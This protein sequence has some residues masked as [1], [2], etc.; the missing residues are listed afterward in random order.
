MNSV[1]L[2]PVPS[3]S[4]LGPGCGPCVWPLRERLALASALLDV[5]NEQIGWQSVSR[6]L[7]RFTTPNRPENWC[8][9]KACAKQYALLLDSVELARRQKFPTSDAQTSG[10]SILSHTPSTSTASGLSVTERLV[11]RLTAERVEE[12]RSRILLGQK[13]YSFLKAKLA[14]LN[15][16]A[17]DSQLQRIHDALLPPPSTPSKSKSTVNPSPRHSVKND[18][19]S[20]KQTVAKACTS[21]SQ[22]SIISKDIHEDSVTINF[23]DSATADQDAKNCEEFIEVWKEIQ[24]FYT[25]PESTWVCPPGPAAPRPASISRSREQTSFGRLSALITEASKTPISPSTP[26]GDDEHH[27]WSQ[28][29]RTQGGSVLTKV[30]VGTRQRYSAKNSAIRFGNRKNASS[31]ILRGV[32]RTAAGSAVPPESESSTNDA[33]SIASRRKV[34]RPRRV[35]SPSG[36]NSSVT[37]PTDEELWNAEN[38]ESDELASTSNQMFS[39]LPTYTI[40]S[41]ASTPSTTAMYSSDTD[42]LMLEGST[43]DEEGGQDIQVSSV[44]RGV[45]NALADHESSDV[46]DDE[47][48]T[49]ALRGSAESL[50]DSSSSSQATEAA[51]QLELAEMEELIS[52][53]TPDTATSQEDD[54]SVTAEET[55]VAQNMEDEQVP[56]LTVAAVPTHPSGSLQETFETQPDTEQYEIRS[57]PN[58]TL[59]LTSSVPITTNQ[60]DRVECAPDLSPDLQT[61]SNVCLSPKTAIYGDSDSVTRRQGARKLSPPNYQRVDLDERSFS[62]ET[63]RALSE[64]SFRVPENQDMIIDPR[65]EEHAEV[66]PLSLTDEQAT[67]VF[68]A[69]SCSDD[70][71]V[72]VNQNLSASDEGNFENRSSPGLTTDSAAQV[73]PVT[74]SKSDS[75]LF[76]GCLVQPT[77]PLSPAAMEAIPATVEELNRPGEEA[78]SPLSRP[79]PFTK[80]ASHSSPNIQ[81]TPASLSDAESA[82]GPQTSADSV[83]PQTPTCDETHW[84]NMSTSPR[85]SVELKSPVLYLSALSDS[86]VKCPTTLVEPSPLHHVVKEVAIELSPANLSQLFPEESDEDHSI[87]TTTQ[88]SRSYNT[89]ERCARKRKESTSKQTVTRSTKNEI[90]DEETK[91]SHRKRKSHDHSTSSPNAETMFE[92]KGSPF[93]SLP[94]LDL[95]PTVSS[96]DFDMLAENRTVTVTLEPITPLPSTSSPDSVPSPKGSPASHLQSGEVVPSGSLPYSSPPSHSI[97]DQS[98]DKSPSLRLR[99]TRRGS[100]MVIVP[101]PLS[102]VTNSITPQHDYIHQYT[103]DRLEF[104]WA[105]DILDCTEVAIAEALERNFPNSS[106]KKSRNL[107]LKAKLKDD[108]TSLLTPIRDNVHKGEITSK[109]KLIRDILCGLSYVRMSYPNLSPQTTAVLEVYD[110]MASRLL[111]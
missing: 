68:K 100:Q 74:P 45:D 102:S 13:C 65:A 94:N 23:H 9:A 7:S 47:P 81:T 109:K 49:P 37:V 67:A 42:E 4:L 40:E 71:G 14:E 44:H 72:C 52:T 59:D 103:S 22:E 46:Q 75:G 32:K 35:R 51:S 29:E 31:K 89:R 54:H 19:D 70:N 62:S 57:S 106:L 2:S 104:N 17:L 60:L 33:S 50:S 27:G 38:S 56:G 28:H 16:G 82:N 80:V 108:F 86:D 85:N 98:V 92:L 73:E 8:S 79:S 5:D 20:V 90:F 99:F 83:L 30:A 48:A 34:G 26:D 10:L 63:S 107:L 43:V 53:V 84:K 1:P 87:E 93:I 69:P 91:H 111:P 64:T 101:S 110:R 21:E 55:D 105:I 24:G 15:S 61:G 39:S 76:V 41:G 78:L 96:D 36:T 66:T 25:I 95:P 58:V 88:L 18:F 77:V 11:K 6:I 97:D 12:L 3:E